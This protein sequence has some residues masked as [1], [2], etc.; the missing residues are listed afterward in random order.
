MIDTSVAN[1]V[2]SLSN[3][4]SNQTHRMIADQRLANA[5]SSGSSLAAAA[6]AA[7]HA[8]HVAHAAHTAA[9]AAAANAAANAAAVTAAGA[10]GS[11]TTMSATQKNPFAIQE[12]LG[13][14]AHG[15]QIKNSSNSGGTGNGNNS[16]QNNPSSNPVSGMGAGFP[17]ISCYNSSFFNSSAVDQYSQAHQRMYFNSAGLFGNLP[18]QRL[19]R[20]WRQAASHLLYSTDRSE[21][22]LSSKPKAFLIHNK[23]DRVFDHKI[24]YVVQGMAI[25]LFKVSHLLARQQQPHI[26]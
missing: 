8:A 16:S 19:R 13:L 20:P 21:H 26:F 25:Y 1:N 6:V 15:D 22:S 18:F 2:N 10:D 9:N 17:P 12:L 11:H 5:A 23:L 4:L 3:Q 14:T 24:V 7:A